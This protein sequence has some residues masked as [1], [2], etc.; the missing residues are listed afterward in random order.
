VLKN[1]SGLVWAGP[2][3]MLFPEIKK[4][5]SNGNRGG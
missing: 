1:A 5:R 2:H 4:G 3:Q